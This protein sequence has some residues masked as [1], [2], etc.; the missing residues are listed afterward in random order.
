M[1]AGTKAP[2]RLFTT[3]DDKRGSSDSGA[4]Q[5]AAKAAAPTP[6]QVAALACSRGTLFH[7]LS[8][9]H[10][11][12]T[13]QLLIHCIA[14]GYTT[15]GSA[16]PG[17]DR[18]SSSSGGSGEAT[19]EQPFAEGQLAA[20]LAEQLVGGWWYATHGVLAWRWQLAA[21]LEA[22]CFGV[23][24]L[25]RYAAARAAWL[26]EQVQLCIDADVCGQVVLLRAGYST[27]AHSLAQP[28][29]KVSCA[30][31][32]QGL[33]AGQPHHCARAH[34]HNRPT[35]PPDPSPPSGAVL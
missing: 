34:A 23:P 31:A 25:C 17:F 8:S 30:A 21:L 7:A 22:P 2:L 15:T 18:S 19:D 9:R 20:A 16:L 6:A 32:G 24:G 14:H 3:L 13:S 5:A 28:G 33:P 35:M 12:S 4:R 10:D 11:L 29:V 1:P 27:L 26:R